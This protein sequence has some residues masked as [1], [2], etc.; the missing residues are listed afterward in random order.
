MIGRT[1]IR[2]SVLPYPAS[3]KMGLLVFYLP[4][5]Q[6]QYKIFLRVHKQN[7][8]KAPYVKMNIYSTSKVNFLITKTFYMSGTGVNED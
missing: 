7:K 2:I 5:F 6:I 4:F 3:K 1:F 8:N